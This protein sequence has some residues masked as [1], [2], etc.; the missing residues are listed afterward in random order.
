MDE[1]ALRGYLEIAKYLHRN[2]KEGCTINAMDWAAGNS[3]YEVV[4]FLH[5]NR[6]EGCTTK[7]KTGPLRVA[8]FLHVNR[9]EGCSGKALGYA[10]ATRKTGATVKMLE[11]VV[12]TLTDVEI[13][14]RATDI[15]NEAT[16]QDWGGDLILLPQYGLPTSKTGLCNVKSRSFYNRLCNLRPDLAG[17]SNM[18]G[19]IIA[20]NT[21]YG[22]INEQFGT[23]VIYLD[24]NDEVDLGGEN[25]VYSDCLHEYVPT[26]QTFLINIPMRNCWMD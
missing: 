2:R 10:V 6:T 9:K 23:A 11:W 16:K 18:L 17:F 19:V 15:W 26:L 7:A 25:S 8:R 12:K 4:K 5:E 21:R 22:T 3:Y 24:D 13:D 1:A 20:N 14:Q